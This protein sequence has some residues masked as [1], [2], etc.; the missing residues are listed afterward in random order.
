[1]ARKKSKSTPGESL[2]VATTGDIEVSTYLEIAKEMG[3]EQPAAPEEAVSGAEREAIIVLDFGSQYNMLIARRV[4]ECQ[5]YCELLPHDTPWE[6]I[7]PL[8]PKGFILSGGPASVYESGAPIAPA[9]IYESG[10][11]ILGICYGMQTITKQLG[12]RVAPGTKREYGHAILHL[13]DVDS[14]LYSGL[15]DFTPVWMSHGDKIE[16]M[17]PG[18]TALAHTENSPFAVMGNGEGVFGLQFHPEVVH[19]PEGK[20]ILKNFVYQICGC[21]GNWTMGNFASESIAKIRSQVGS[22][23]VINALSGGV[24]SSVV[25]TVIHQAIGDQLTCIFV[26]NGLLRHEEAERTLNVF[27]KNLGMNII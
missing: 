14:V 22:G 19:T 12:G 23:R 8:N 24:D 20:N 3:G 17:P 6:K 10:L 27:Q 1:M 21:R 18:F 25:A 26:N 9:Y 16:E 2:R 11:P 7:A 4:R 15:P 5:V 13:S